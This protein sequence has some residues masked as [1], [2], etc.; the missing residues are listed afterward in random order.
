MAT[1]K[2]DIVS[3][4][5]EIYSGA[6]SMV[7]APAKMGEVGIAPRHAPMLTP[8][9]PGEV[10]VQDE[11]GKEEGFY[12]TG[13]LLEVQPYLVTVLANTALRGDQLDEAAAL[14]SQQE[15]EEALKGASEETDI[16][17]AQGE[18]AEARARYRAA[19][20]LKGKR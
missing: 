12:I 14:T 18:L 11:N 9:S 2:V 17:R 8:L 16:A 10:R 5:G 6:A 20:K 7:F 3:A 4:E 13:G 1:I 15:A 19:Q